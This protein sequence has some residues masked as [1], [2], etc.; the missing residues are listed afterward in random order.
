MQNENM[1]PTRDTWEFGDDR[2]FTNSS[3]FKTGCKFHAYTGH[4]GNAN[5]ERWLGRHW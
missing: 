1:C 2:S 4:A 3:M 5:E